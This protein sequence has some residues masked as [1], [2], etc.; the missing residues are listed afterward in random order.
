MGSARV[1]SI[2]ISGASNCVSTSRRPLI[3]GFAGRMRSGK[4][5]A[6]RFL[7]GVGFYH[8]S[9]A[10]AIKDF[11]YA[12]NPIIPV[13]VNIKGGPIPTEYVRLA[14]VVDA[15]G[16]EAAKDHHP[17][18]RKLLQRCGTDAG[19]KIIGDRV[20]VDTA[21]NR[22]PPSM[23]V[24]FSDVR[25]PNEADAIRAWGGILIRIDRPDTPGLPGEAHPS[26]S[27]LDDY[28]FHATVVNDGTVA[29]LHAKVT[30]ALLTARR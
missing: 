15:E 19:R 4:D 28:P 9:F 12:L 29:D 22:L 24:T 16:W 27:A 8:A 23:D 10:T 6:A 3:V 26:E 1:D 18:V 2:T 5:T 7:A 17:E 21:M 14:E 13:S 30:V 20:W 25:F 11:T